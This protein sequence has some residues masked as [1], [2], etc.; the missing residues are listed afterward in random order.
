MFENRNGVLSID[1]KLLSV[2]PIET[3]TSLSRDEYPTITCKIIRDYSSD[4]F[5][6]RG[7]ANAK[8]A[9]FASNNYSYEPSIQ[10]VI[11]NDPATIVF[12]TDGSKTVVKCQ[13][14]D[15][16]SEELGLAMAIAKKFLGNTGSYN[17]V[18][19]RFI[20]QKRSK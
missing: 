10:N 18:F 16:F 8:T 6:M 2:I 15:T 5:I 11:F 1:G 17:D 19:K 3:T 20:M 13:P 4:S 9:L 7:R 14:G 12:W